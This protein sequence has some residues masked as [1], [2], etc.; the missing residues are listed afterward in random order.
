MKRS[1]K[2]RRQG[3]KK[4]LIE[5]TEASRRRDS[6][7]VVKA[8]GAFADVFSALSLMEF[9]K[10]LHPDIMLFVLPHIEVSHCDDDPNALELLIGFPHDSHTWNEER[11]T[12]IDRQGNP[13]RPEDHGLGV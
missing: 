5:V 7:A 11:H 10:D 3:R 4:L 13:W 8:L 6:A 1:S 2:R 9:V 12:W